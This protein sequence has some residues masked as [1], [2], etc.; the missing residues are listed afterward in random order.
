MIHPVT[1]GAMHSP[2]SCAGHMRTMISQ[3]LRCP[4]KFLFFMLSCQCVILTERQ[5]HRL[6][7]LLFPEW[8]HCTQAL[9]SS[10]PE[11]PVRVM[12]LSCTQGVFFA[13]CCCYHWPHLCCSLK[14][15]QPAGSGRRSELSPG[16]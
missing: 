3:L 11:T 16:Q 10:K 13:W 5:V 7:I 9:V 1:H 4:W 15:Q 8:L 2:C 12:C 6:L 14:S